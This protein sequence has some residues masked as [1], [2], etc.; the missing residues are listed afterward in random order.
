MH[1][2]GSKNAQIRLVNFWLDIE[3]FFNKA[4]YDKLSRD[5]GNK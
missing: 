4:N 2:I 5:L 3:Q 1:C